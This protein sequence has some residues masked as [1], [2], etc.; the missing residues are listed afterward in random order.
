MMRIYNSATFKCLCYA[1]YFY[2]LITVYH[3]FHA[4]SY[5]TSF[6]ETSGYSKTMT[7]RFGSFPA[8]GFGSGLE[9]CNETIVFQIFYSKG[10]RIHFDQTRQVVHMTFTCKHICRCGK[11]TVRALSQW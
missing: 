10:K 7:G 2:F 11:S 1:N 6:F 9:N 5:M 4:C 8:K 3:H